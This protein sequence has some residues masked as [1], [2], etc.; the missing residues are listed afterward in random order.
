LGGLSYSR[1]VSGLRRSGFAV[2][3]KMLADIAVRDAATFAQLVERAR[4]HLQV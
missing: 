2:N 1:F 4:A 3:R